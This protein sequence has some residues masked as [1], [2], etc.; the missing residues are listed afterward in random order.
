M[1]I[2][3]NVTYSGPWFQRRGAVVHDF[4]REAREEVAQQAFA[5]VHEFLN[6]QIVHPTPYYETQ[7]M[8]DHDGDK[9]LVHDRGIIYGPWLEGVSTRNRATRFRGYASFR[10]ATQKVEAKVPYLVDAALRRLIARL[11]G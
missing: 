4:M 9:E 3:V 1:M 11:T 5:D 8:R 10:K 7:I 2:K 6:A